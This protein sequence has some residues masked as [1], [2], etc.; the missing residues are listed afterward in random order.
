MPPQ[1]QVRRQKRVRQLWREPAQHTIIEQ[2]KACRATRNTSNQA[3]VSRLML[4]W[5][6]IYGR[7]RK[8]STL[9][10]RKRAHREGVARQ[11]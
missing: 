10:A 2:E 5:K 9:L 6:V 11:G 8:R 4:R 7:P 3:A 1:R